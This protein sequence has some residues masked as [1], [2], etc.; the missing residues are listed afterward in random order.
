[1]ILRF[2]AEEYAKKHNMT[3]ALAQQRLRHMLEAGEV[4]RIRAKKLNGKYQY[5]AKN[6]LKAHD[7]F[8]LGGR[9]HG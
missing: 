8:N 9:Q 7:P 5:E 1:V 4:T 6:N 3:V 2:T